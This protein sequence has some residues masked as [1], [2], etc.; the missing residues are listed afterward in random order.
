MLTPNGHTNG[1]YCHASVYILENSSASS[2]VKFLQS[3]LSLICV[4][5]VIILNERV[6]LKLVLMSFGRVLHKG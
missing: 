6:L 5:F 2:H 1:L 3:F 4:I